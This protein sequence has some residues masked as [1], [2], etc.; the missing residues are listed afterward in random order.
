MM[1]TPPVTYSNCYT[2]Y[3]GTSLREFSVVTASRPI[4]SVGAILC[5]AARGSETPTICRKYQH[6]LL[7]PRSNIVGDQLNRLYYTDGS[8]SFLLCAFG[9]QVN[10]CA[11][12]AGFYLSG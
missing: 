10:P 2:V 5:P 11:I 9:P 8:E 6:L 4:L 12:L 3:V 7:K 1:V